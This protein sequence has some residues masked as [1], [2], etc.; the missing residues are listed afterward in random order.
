MGNEWLPWYG[1]ECPVD[2][3][4]LVDVTHRDGEKHY[5]VNPQ[6]DC[7]AACVWSHDDDIG[8]I[9]FWRVSEQ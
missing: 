1:G 4:C 3:D 2:G 8:D 9:I 6:D 7:G 5:S